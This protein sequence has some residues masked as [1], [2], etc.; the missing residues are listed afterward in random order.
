MKRR[1]KM[2]ALALE[3]TDVQ[4]G[5]RRPMRVVEVDR[6]EPDDLGPG[7]VL[8]RVRR[9]MFC[10]TDKELGSQPGHGIPTEGVLVPGLGPV[11][12]V[13]H[14]AGGTIIAAGAE[15]PQRR[16]GEDVTLMVR[17]GG[18]CAACR[19]HRSDMCY[20][21]TE[22]GEMGEHGIFRLPGWICSHAVVPQTHALRI[23]E[24]LDP[25]LSCFGE[26]AS[27]GGKALCEARIVG[28]RYP[29]WGVQDERGNE[30][31][32]L[33]LGA[34]GVGLPTVP[35]LMAHG[36]QVVVAA[37]TVYDPDDPHLKASLV[38]RLGARYVSTQQVTVPELKALAPK[39]RYDLIVDMCGRS[40]VVAEVMTEL[41][42]PGTIIVLTSITGGDRQVAFPSDRFLHNITMNNG[43]II[44]IVNA[45]VSHFQ[46]GLAGI[47]WAESRQPGWTE[48]LITRRFSSLSQAAEGFW[49]VMDDSGNIRAVVELC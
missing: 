23:P 40:D 25:A 32:A 30:P 49:E 48:A 4:G 31:A 19:A 9:A 41:C 24:G 18:D 5:G 37:W 22:P 8:V 38:N 17:E 2:E 45:S 47:I 26:P 36:F 39:G 28:Q 12:L 7:D 3:M 13:G 15:V 27:I 6:P 20:R 10:L 1:Q 43:T 14:E 11:T 44:G 46:T 35:T 21:W 33:V 34:G 16:V 42:D 29:G